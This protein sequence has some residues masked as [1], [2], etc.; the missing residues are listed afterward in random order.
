M[1][2]VLGM[3]GRDHPAGRVALLGP[4]VGTPCLAVVKISTTRSGAGKEG[5][6]QS[7]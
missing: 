4:D 3:R 6:I 7:L 2:G 1:R 5:A